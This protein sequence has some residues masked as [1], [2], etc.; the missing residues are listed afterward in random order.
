MYAIACVA[1]FRVSIVP[2]ARFFPS[3]LH[4][5]LSFSSVTNDRFSP[6]LLLLLASGHRDVVAVVRPSV[7]PLTSTAVSPLFLLRP[8]RPLDQWEASGEEGGK[9]SLLFSPSPFV[10]PPPSRTHARGK[11]ECTCC[12]CFLFSHRP[13]YSSSSPKPE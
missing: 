11:S 8:P 2:F 6:P 9:L 1:F 7:H 12:C 10:R 4:I 13:S 5:R 3:F